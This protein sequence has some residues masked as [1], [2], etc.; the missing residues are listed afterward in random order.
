MRDFTIQVSNLPRIKDYKNPEILKAML[1]NH[2]E[3]VAMVQSQEIQCLRR[4]QRYYNQ[5]VDVFFGKEEY[6]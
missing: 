6:G 4:T 3:N 2:F 1:F 5:I